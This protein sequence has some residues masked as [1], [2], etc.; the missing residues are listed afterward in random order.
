MFK[1]NTRIYFILTNVR[2]IYYKA[3][4][5]KL[6]VYDKTRISKDKFIKEVKRLRRLNNKTNNKK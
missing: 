5:N 6:K 3:K 2:P 1:T 4:V